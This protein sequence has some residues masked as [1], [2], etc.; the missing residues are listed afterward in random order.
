MKSDCQMDKRQRQAW[1]A[2]S[3]GPVWEPRR[4]VPA[5]APTVMDVMEAVEVA[6]PS[7]SASPTWPSLRQAVAECTGCPRS[8]SRSAPVFGSGQQ[9]AVW[10]V[11]ADQPDETDDASGEP[12]SGVVGQLLE[13]MLNAIGVSRGRDV[14]ITQAMKCRAA[15]DRRP[16]HDEIA[17]CSGHLRHQIELLRPSLILALGSSAARS[18]L[19]VGTSDRDLRGRVHVW[20]GG[21]L[22]IPVVVTHDLLALLRHPQGKAQAWSDLRLARRTLDSQGSSGRSA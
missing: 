20:Q 9:K 7:A 2:L 12:C 14:F 1:R 10:M 13:Q 3:L 18:V 19:S 6:V 16:Q 8:L 21:A 4:L 22:Q 5:K 17:V 15:D 11:V